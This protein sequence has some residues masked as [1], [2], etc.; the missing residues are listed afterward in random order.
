MPD[1]RAGRAPGGPS[2]DPNKTEVLT[3]SLAT[4]FYNCGLERQARHDFPGAVSDFGHALGFDPAHHGARYGR[5]FAHCALLN[6]REAVADLLRILRDGLDP[7]R[8]D[9]LRL[10]V[11]G[12][13]M[14]MGKHRE[15]VLELREHFSARNLRRI[16]GWHWRL[17]GFLMGEVAEADLLAGLHA[18]D[19]DAL[20]LTACE[21]HWYAAGP[22]LAGGR[23]DAAAVHLRRCVA[24]EVPSLA[25]WWAARAELE[26]LPC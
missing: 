26:R 9:G 2:R 19:T 17:A 6:W 8:E 4:V 14:R 16:S 12:L 22:P 7:H 11:G 10:Q 25:V 21:A 13:R 5:A 23:R 15:A 1:Q 18:P 20:R 24:L 3:P